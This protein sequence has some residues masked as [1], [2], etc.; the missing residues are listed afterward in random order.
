MDGSLGAAS[1]K[2]RR[3]VQ[4]A[5]RQF[6]PAGSG[7][8]TAGFSGWRAMK[9]WMTAGHSSAVVRDTQ[10]TEASATADWPRPH[11]RFQGGIGSNR[12]TADVEHDEFEDGRRPNAQGSRTSATSWVLQ[13][14]LGCPLTQGRY[15]PS[16]SAPGEQPL[17]FLKL[18]LVGSALDSSGAC[19]RWQLM[20]GSSL[21]AHRVT[22]ST[23]H[24]YRV[25]P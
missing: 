10:A 9:T 4:G 24:R 1:S 21:L 16:D 17:H 3:S 7:H 6:A 14:A 5:Q 15:R 11:V 23:N 2:Q 19:S 8:W 25:R 22:E 20:S 18:K 13:I 12:C